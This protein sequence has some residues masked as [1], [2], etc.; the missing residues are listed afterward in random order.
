VAELDSSPRSIQS[1]YGWYADKKLWVNRRYQR[2]L[3]WTLEE[4]QKLVASVLSGYPIPAI[5]LAEREDGYEV[6]DGVQRLH[7]FMSFI[8]TAFATESGR[9][10]DVEQFP[11]AHTRSQEGAFVISDEPE[12]RLSAREVGTYLDYS[13]A[14]SIM[15]GATDEDID[16][17]FSRINTYGHRLSDQ[18]RRQ[19][20]VQNNFSELVRSLS[21]AIRGDVSQDILTL[22]DMPEISIDLPMAKHGY[23]VSAS[24]VFWVRQGV[25]R[26]TDLRDAMDEQCVA[27]IAASVVGGHI[28][29]RSK[30]ALD[31][32][33]TNGSEESDRIEAALTSYGADKFATE[34]KYLIDQVDAICQSTEPPTKLRALLFS[35][36]TTNPFPAVFTVLMIA[37][38]E[39]LIVD[40]QKIADYAAT[41][42]GLSNLDRRVDTSR[43]STSPEERRQNVNT[44]KGLISPQ[45]VPAE[46]RAL[47]DDQTATDIDGAIRR[48]D[49]EAPHYELK[50]GLLRLDSSKQIDPGMLEKI[51]HTA[52][53]IA[54]NGPDRSG[55]LLVGVTD[56]E[57]DKTRVE[58]LYGVS[59]R[60][61]GRKFAVGVRREADAL[62]ESM[63][64]YFGRIKNA[65]QN[66]DLSEPLKSAVLASIGFNDYFGLGI[67]VVNVPAQSGVSTVGER[68]FARSGDST[69]EVTGQALIDVASRF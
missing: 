31:A 58:E 22:G 16:E 43:G 61:V 51:I 2:K 21:S 33:Y 1:L 7:T 17:V 65:V 57:A 44:V 29:A 26:S 8:E 25:L 50:Q 37:L 19:A 69:I 54:N 6:I 15:R 52:C 14:I 23:R 4:K 47:Y 42:A 45:L 5:L 12:T 64:A 38:H 39:L 36:Q 46:G 30:D 60:A 32:I 40:D 67:V 10:F 28:I 9:S 62:G 41:Q 24:D 56:T 63:E 49:I 66:S 13:V 18:E 53:A 34:L 48:S 27:D 35:R 3:V 11:T 68:V 20:G 55:V 59:P